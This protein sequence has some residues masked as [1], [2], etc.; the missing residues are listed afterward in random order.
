[1]TYLTFGKGEL[2]NAN[3]FLSLYS[4]F[5]PCYFGYN[6]SLFLFR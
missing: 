5:S 4:Y 2:Q 1:M 6:H 3:R